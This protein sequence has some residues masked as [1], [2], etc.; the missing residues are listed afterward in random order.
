MK[1][2]MDLRDR[3]SRKRTPLKNALEQTIGDK[4]VRGAPIQIRRFPRVEDLQ[5]CH[6]LFISESKKAIFPPFC[7]ESRIKAS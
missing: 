7:A 1:E 3:H 4:T 5:P 2:P 6:I